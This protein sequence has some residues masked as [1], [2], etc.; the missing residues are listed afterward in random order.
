MKALLGVIVKPSPE[1]LV[2]KYDKNT[3]HRNAANDHRGVPFL[4][5][6]GNIGAETICLQGGVSP[7]SEFSDDTGIPCATSRRTSTGHPEREDG[8]QNQGAPERPA[9]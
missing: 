2:R 8:G 6:L 7:G 3:H 4:C 5:H 9:A 1:Q